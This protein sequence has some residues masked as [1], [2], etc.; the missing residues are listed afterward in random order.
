MKKMRIPFDIKYTLV[1][2]V[3]NNLKDY[4]LVTIIFVIGMFVRGYVY[5]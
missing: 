1:E 2:Y 4:I 5:K 3:K